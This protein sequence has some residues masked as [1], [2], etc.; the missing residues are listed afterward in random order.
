LALLPASYNSVARGV[1]I[2][3]E[4]FGALGDGWTNDTIAFQ[5]MAAAINAAGGGTIEFRSGAVYILGKQTL[6]KHPGPLM[7]T[8][9]G[10]GAINACTTPVTII[11]NG[12]TLKFAN[13][14]RYGCFNADGT[15]AAANTAGT[16][17]IPSHYFEGLLTIKNC[18]ARVH[19]RDVN[20]DGNLPNF[21]IGGQDHAPGDSG[22]QIP[23][24]GLMVFD[25]VGG[26]FY[27]NIH[28]KDA[29]RD[30]IMAW[31]STAAAGNRKIPATFRG[32]TADSC[33]RLAFSLT[34]GIGYSFFN[35]RGTNSGSGALGSPPL[36]G[37]DIE[38]EQAPIRDVLISDSAFYGNNNTALVADSGDS[39]GIRLVRS[40]FVGDINWGAW[41][42][43]QFVAEECLFLGPT[44]VPYEDGD[45][46]KAGKF[47]RCKF[48]DDPRLSPTGAL[49]TGN[50]IINGAGGSLGLNTLYDQCRID[51]G[52]QSYGPAV[53]GSI[54]RDCTINVRSPHKITIVNGKFRGKNRIT[55]PSASMEN[56]PKFVIENG[57]ELLFNRERHIHNL[58][59]RIA[60][61]EQKEMSP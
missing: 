10:L 9:A 33:G 58:E 24:D 35:V 14:L 40:T 15:A 44:N 55:A 42:N 18:S 3:P 8:P 38:S 17:S 6:T 52:H 16:R 31:R 20:I 4:K 51:A 54:F 21:L 47:F 5:K 25:N 36:A 59:H 34:G 30:G 60:A 1:A 53:N 22:W 57:G 56:L 46:S 50:P 19:V 32:C 43:K 29:P 39:A 49:A 11:G 61:L 41:L 26:E 37:M 27:E 13:G 23:G 45:Q 12:A 7:Y 48:S 2:T 28:V